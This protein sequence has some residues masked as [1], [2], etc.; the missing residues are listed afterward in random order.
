MDINP[1]QHDPEFQDPNAAAEDG[2]QAPFRLRARA[3]MPPAAGTSTWAQ[4][5]VIPSTPVYG[6]DG[7][8]VGTVQESY[9][10]AFL[11]TS[12]FF[13]TQEYYI[14]YS[15][16]ATADAERIVL[17]STSEEAKQTWRQRS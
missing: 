11:M 12:G 2:G 3:E 14:P 4:R 15:A 8:R 17:H 1:G 16:I 7:K 9:A 6:S 13:F 10:D 5:D